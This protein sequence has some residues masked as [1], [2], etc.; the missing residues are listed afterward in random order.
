[1]KN[2]RN[3]LV[4]CAALLAFPASG[5]RAH[6]QFGTGFNLFSTSQDVELGKAAAASAEKQLPLVTT[7]AANNLVQRV[8]HRLASQAGGANYPYT[9][10]VVNLSDLNAFALPGGYVYVHRGLLEGVRTEGELAGVMAHEIAH[11]ALRHP[12]QQIS[13]AYGASAGLGLLGALLGGGSSSRSTQ[14]VNT[15]GN[16]GMSTL[17]LKFSR[18]AEAEAD[19]YGAQI[20]AKAGYDPMEMANFFGY[21]QSQS[22]TNP[23]KVATFFSSHP[24]ASDRQSHIRAEARSLGGGRSTL[25]GGLGDAKLELQRLGPAPRMSQVVSAGRTGLR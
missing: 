19:A 4:L 13:K 9:F 3:T 14:I 25:V 17:F 16:L 12:T 23:S 20:M 21:M 2:I 22:K 24:S 8:G 18:S 11:V 10:K 6:Q 5:A 7:R 1:M 15:L